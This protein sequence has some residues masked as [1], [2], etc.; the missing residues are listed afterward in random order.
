M[1]YIRSHLLMP[2]Q[3]VEV[4]PAIAGGLAVVESR[5]LIAVCKLGTEIRQSKGLAACVLVLTHDY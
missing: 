1:D 3:S 5:C 2:G 4:D